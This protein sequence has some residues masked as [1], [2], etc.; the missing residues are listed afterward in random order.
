MKCEEAS[1]KANLSE[2]NILRLIKAAKESAQRGGEVLMSQYGKINSVKSKSNEGDLVTNADIASEAVVIKY[3]KK[4]T[5]E[6]SILAEESGEEGDQE[7]LRW[8]IDPLDGTTNF[9]HGYPFFATSVGLTWNSVPI[10]GCIDIP[11]LKETYWAAPG[12]GAVCNGRYLKVSSPKRLSESLLITGFSY[13]RKTRLDNN[14]AEFCSLTHLTRGVRRG[15]AAAVDLAFLA[16]GRIDGYWERG[17]SQWDLAAGVAI[18]EQAGGD[19][20]DYRSCEFDLRNGRILACSP[21]IKAELLRVLRKVK[22]LKG[23][24]YGAPEVTYIGS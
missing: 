14:Y 4:Y 12:H 19:I 13:D 15:G 24:M 10:L 3:L 23:E 5:P 1:K 22:P 2:E 8:C 17:L 18:V 20:C 6:I 16:A 7:G 21:G 11:F 9:A